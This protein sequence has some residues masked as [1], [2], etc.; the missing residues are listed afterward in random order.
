M[1]QQQEIVNVVLGGVGGQG[2]LV[3]SDILAQVALKAG[4]DVKKSEVH[5]MAQRGG[6]VVSHVRFGARIFSPLVGKNEADFL[7]AFEQLE[8]LRYLDFLKPDGIAVVNEQQILPMTVFTANQV[9]PENIPEMVSQQGRR[10]LG[11]E[12]IKI[13]EE[14]GNPRLLNVILLG[15]LARFLNFSEQDWLA[16]IKARV[17]A[18]FYEL[19]HH[20][21]LR[22]KAIEGKPAPLDVK[23]SPQV[24]KVMH[25]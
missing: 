2:V 23:I 3:A 8:C 20:G 14:M 9:Y 15:V 6:S 16:G 1:Q 7:V 12:G 4:F 17:P 19:N 18:R 10:Y 24:V 25:A 11:I 13:A 5:G 22:G 21:F